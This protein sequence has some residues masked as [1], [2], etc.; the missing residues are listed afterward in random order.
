MADSHL[1]PLL[2]AI[3]LLPAACGGHRDNDAQSSITIELPPA[4]TATPRPG[5][6]LE[7]PARAAQ[8]GDERAS[9]AVHE[10]AESSR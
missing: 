1:R 4:R 5:F 2:I 10:L 9:Q 3:A 8:P 6:S 7:A